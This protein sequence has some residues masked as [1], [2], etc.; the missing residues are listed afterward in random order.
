MEVSEKLIIWYN[1]NKRDLPWRRTHDPYLIWIS[2]IILQQTR[3]I[4]GL[5]YYMAFV[6]HYP[7]V[8]KLANAPEEE[9]LKLWQGL[10]YYSRARNMHKAAKMILETYSG[11]FPSNYPDILQ[12]PGIGD[13]T[14]AAIASFAYNLCY[15]VIDGN[16]VRFVSRFL[17][18]TEISGSTASNTLIRQWLE[19]KIPQ[20]EAGIFNQS[21]MEFGALGCTPQNPLCKQPDSFCPFQEECYAFQKE[22][23]DLL[24]IKKNKTEKSVW[25]LHYL[26]FME[27]DRIWIRKRPY[28]DL[29]RGMFD[30]PLWKFETES[31]P[32]TD[33]T[34]KISKWE[35]SSLI[36]RQKHLSEKDS[37]DNIL[38]LKEI[39]QYRQTLSHRRIIFHF[40]QVD[41]PPPSIK[42]L[43]LS[44]TD[45]LEVER[46]QLKNFAVP[47]TIEK[48]FSDFNII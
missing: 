39:K 20:K 28:D 38:K 31:T 45:L 37:I 10:G 11:V 8:E 6:D 24:P 13:Y 46:K 41:N 25:H 18:I 12:L 35:E 5:P 43:L 14:A 30:L 44:Q 9:V 16:V 3:I 27:D 17:G 34:G 47:K 4:Q 21:I 48:F 19:K 23:V 7:S 32:G 42:R 2:E 1:E 22:V 26:L 15:P 40:Y 33:S 36:Y 29:W